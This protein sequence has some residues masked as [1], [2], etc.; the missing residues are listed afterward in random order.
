MRELERQ[1]GAICRAVAAR[2]ARGEARETHV[3]P[4]LVQELLGP[5]KYISE[6]KLATGKPGVAP[7]SPGRRPAGRSCTLKL[8]AMPAEATFFLPAKSAR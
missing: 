5:P 4:E 7:A 3:T 1:I 2:V 8:C 6:S